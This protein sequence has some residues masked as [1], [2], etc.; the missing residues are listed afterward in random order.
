MQNVHHFETRSEHKIELHFC[1][2]NLFCT[3]EISAFQYN[4]K[5]TSL[6]LMK[7]CVWFYWT[8]IS[9]MFNFH[10]NTFVISKVM[11]IY[12]LTQE[13]KI[14][15]IHYQL[16]FNILLS[17]FV[18]QFNRGAWGIFEFQNVIP[19]YNHFLYQIA[20]HFAMFLCRIVW[21]F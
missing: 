13:L 21:I 20:I 6:K 12:I 15:K 19:F 1:T 16:I 5:T 3:Q 4:L 17:N 11:S 2:Q 7:F 9:N 8:I 18:T 14:A 10:C